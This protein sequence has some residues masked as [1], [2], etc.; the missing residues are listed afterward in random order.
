MGAE[1]RGRS[2]GKSK[3]E[4][5]KYQSETDRGGGEREEKRSW[6]EMRRDEQTTGEERERERGTKVAR[7]RQD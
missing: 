3:A 7:G 1:K 6:V 5:N 2:K 4:K